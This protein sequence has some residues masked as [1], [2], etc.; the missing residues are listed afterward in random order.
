LASLAK[1]EDLDVGTEG[2]FAK[3]FE[4]RQ[5]SAQRNRV[6]A[7]LLL[8]NEMTLKIM[9]QMN[10]WS[11]DNSETLLKSFHEKADPWREV[12]GSLFGFFNFYYR[13]VNYLCRHPSIRI[14]V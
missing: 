12:F 2:L 3:L 14:L 5:P 11:A 7:E 10:S 13:S 6:R 1:S 9:N 8:I 4:K